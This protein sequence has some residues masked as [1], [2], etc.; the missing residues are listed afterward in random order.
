MDLLLSI[1]GGL[2]IIIYLND[3]YY[4]AGHSSTP[5]LQGFIQWGMGG[6]PPMITKW[7]GGISPITSLLGNV[8]LK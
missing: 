3:L 6:G 7:G 2:T 4:T 1:H 8:V 5:L